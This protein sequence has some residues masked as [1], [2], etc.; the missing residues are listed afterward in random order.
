M[1]LGSSVEP[2]RGAALVYAVTLVAVFGLLTSLVIR[3]TRF[4]DAL[5]ARDR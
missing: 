2:Q 3:Y 1:G 5:V 4:N